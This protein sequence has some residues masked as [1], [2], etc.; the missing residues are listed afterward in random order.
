MDN[1][2][3][4][5]SSRRHRQLLREVSSFS[6]RSGQTK[7]HT[8]TVNPSS[9]WNSDPESIIRAVGEVLR[10]SLSPTFSGIS[11]T[12]SVRKT[13]T[14]GWIRQGSWPKSVSAQE[15]TACGKS[16]G[17]A[18][19]IIQAVRWSNPDATCVEYI[20]YRL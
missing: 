9:E 10:Q 17:P 16:K 8:P 4:S 20:Q 2:K 13:M 14:A 18:V 1:T 7:E 5:T 3:S 6:P 15:T 12:D 11:P 19:E